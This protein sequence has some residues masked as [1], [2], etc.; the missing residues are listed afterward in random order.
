MLIDTEGNV[1][2]AGIAK[3]S[4]I[5]MLDE[6]ALEVAHKN[7]FSPGIQNDRA[8]MVWVKYEVKFVLAD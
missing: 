8:V 6:A 2:E 7:R 5:D 3:S 1:V 4:E